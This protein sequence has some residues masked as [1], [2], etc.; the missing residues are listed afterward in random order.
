MTSFMNYWDT[1]VYAC[2]LCY[3]ASPYNMQYTDKTIFV[4]NVYRNFDISATNRTEGLNI[5]V[6]EFNKN[7]FQ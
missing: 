4:L 6:N 2:S 1:S 5:T 7:A 3:F